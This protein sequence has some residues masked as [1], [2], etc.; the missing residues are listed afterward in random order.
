LAISSLIEIFVTRFIFDST[1]D[2]FGFFIREPLAF[3]YV[4]WS[5][6]YIYRQKGRQN[7]RATVN[8]FAGRNPFDDYLPLEYRLPQA[9]RH[10]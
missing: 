8:E 2:L 9:A 1:G 10:A 4:R 7:H 5:I 6:L 3:R